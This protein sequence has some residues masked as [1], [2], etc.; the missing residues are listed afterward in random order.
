MLAAAER[1]DRSLALTIEVIFTAV[2]IYIYLCDRALL[3][4]AKSASSTL[5]EKACSFT[6]TCIIGREKLALFQ[7]YL[8]CGDIS[9]V[10][11]RS[12]RLGDL[13]PTYLP[14]YFRKE[15]AALLPASVRNRAS[16]TQ[17]KKAVAASHANEMLEAM[18]ISAAMYDFDCVES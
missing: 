15:K 16:T 13:L 10:G 14:T 5:H 6:T 2:S 9:G 1:I 18:P 17:R 8:S 12:G 11:V 7:I 4:R 3:H